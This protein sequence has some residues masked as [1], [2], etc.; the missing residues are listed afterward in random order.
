[1]KAT[2][3]PSPSAI[4]QALSR[5]LHASAPAPRACLAQLEIPFSGCTGCLLMRPDAGT[6]EERH[7]EL[8]TPLLHRICCK[9]VRRVSIG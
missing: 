2:A 3:H 8:H 9:F 6:V 7:P 5:S 4:T 1:M